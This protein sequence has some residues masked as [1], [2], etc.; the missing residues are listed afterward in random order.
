MID[1]LNATFGIGEQLL[2][3]QHASGLTQGIIRTE[4]C[5]GSFFLLG[6]HLASFQPRSQAQ[7]VLFMSGEAVYE[8]GK[9]IRGGV[10][11]CFPWFGPNKADPAAPAHGTVRTQLWQ[12]RESRMTADGLMIALGI[13]QPSF[14][15]LFRVVFGDSLDMS[16]QIKNATQAEQCCE[17]ALHTYFQ[18]S[19]V[20][21]VQVSGLE[22]Q[23]YRDQLTGQTVAPTGAPIRFTEETDRVYHGAVAEIR[24]NDP[25]FQRT[26][27][28]RP[29]AS[30]STVV[31][32]PWIAK[33][34]RLAD[35]GDQEYLTMCCIETANVATSGWLIP[36]GKEQTIGVDISCV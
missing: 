26:I 36:A 3:Q 18:L 11:I 13:D 4:R 12:M 30:Q 33:S 6:A 2:F 27:V 15:L 34:Q 35:F 20:H 1:Q 10:P 28:V 21:A 31:W 25:G 19:D 22:K 32:N 5:T 17:V 29:R 16:L 24:L 23:A 7:P 8:V 9:P 14:S